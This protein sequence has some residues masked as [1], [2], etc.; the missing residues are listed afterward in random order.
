MGRW[1]DVTRDGLKYVK[2]LTD[3]HVVEAV[4]FGTAMKILYLCSVK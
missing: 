1:D 4:K 3:F 2:L